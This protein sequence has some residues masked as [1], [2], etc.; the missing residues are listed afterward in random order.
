MSGGRASLLP[1]RPLQQLISRTV[2]KDE[3]PSFI[4]A[5]FSD[6]KTTSMVDCLRKSDA[7]VFIDV[8]D[9][10]CHHVLNSEEFVDLFPLRPPHPVG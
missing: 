9:G 2:P 6:E 1:P 7:Q 8:I 3:L 10:V 5:I 4:E